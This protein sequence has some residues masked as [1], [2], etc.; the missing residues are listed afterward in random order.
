MKAAATRLALCALLLMPASASADLILSYDVNIV[1]TQVNVGDT[2]D[3]Q[4]FATVSGTSNVGGNFGLAR[5]SVSLQDSF[6]E[7]IAPGTI[8]SAFSFPGGYSFPNGGATMPSGLYNL[9]TLAI[10]QNALNAATS[11]GSYLLASGQYVV[12]QLG[13]H[14]LTALAGPDPS[15]YFT[16]AGQGNGDA[17]IYNQTNFGFDTVNAVPEPSSLVMCGLAAFGGWRLRR[18]RAAQREAS[19]TL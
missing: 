7:T 18:R 8:A 19:N 1:Q 4:I 10:E 17:L 5:A 2:I 16:A 11:P 14:T 13:V 12:T 6:S 3:W 15:T 9:G